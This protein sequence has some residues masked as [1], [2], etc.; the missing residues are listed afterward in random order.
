MRRFDLERVLEYFFWICH[1]EHEF[2][3]QAQLIG[4]HLD[5]F[6]SWYNTP[7]FKTAREKAE[8]LKAGQAQSFG[9]YVF[10]QLTPEAQKV[11]KRIKDCWLDK[12]TRQRP[13]QQAS[14]HREMKSLGRKIRQELFIHALVYSNYNLSE[15]CRLTGVSYNQLNGWRREDTGFKRLIEEVEWHKK[16]F[17]EH[18]LM[19]LVAERYPAAVLF[20]NRTIN[21]DRGYSERLTLEHKMDPS[22]G[23]DDLDLDLETRKKIL[24]AIR[25][26]KAVSSHPVID[27]SPVPLLDDRRAGN[28]SSVED[29]GEGEDAAA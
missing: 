29:N 8:E 13:G 28:G 24:E 23:L 9:E 22:F 27:V 21:A 7:A 14:L 6:K 1:G 15:A 10:R 2:T 11:W 16:N 4:V 5:T 18:A 17:F 26:K 20:V 25:N 12:E 19:D 3:K